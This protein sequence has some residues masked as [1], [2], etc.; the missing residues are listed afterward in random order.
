MG[1][2]NSGNAIDPVTIDERMYAVFRDNADSD[3]VKHLGFLTLSQSNITTKVIGFADAAYTNG[4]TATIKVNSNTTTQSSLTPGTE[5][6]VQGNGSTGTSAHAQA[7]VKAGIAL[8]STKLLI[9]Q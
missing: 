7:T 4:Q 9:R 1:T 3:K 2:D 5:Y 6:Y 8:T